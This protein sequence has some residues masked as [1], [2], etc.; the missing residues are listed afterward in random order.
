VNE[1]I[2]TRLTPPLKSA[3]DEAPCADDLLA[4][5]WYAELSKLSVT[6]IEKLEE[7]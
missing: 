6:T 2:G 1:N 4:Q 3:D 7:V 5:A